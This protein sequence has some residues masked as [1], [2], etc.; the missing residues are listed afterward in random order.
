MNANESKPEFKQSNSVVWWSCWVAIALMLVLTAITLPQASD[1]VPIHWGFDGKPNQNAPALLALMLIPLT[2]I[3]AL[4]LALLL[5]KIDPGRANYRNFEASYWKVILAFLIYLGGFHGLVCYAAAGHEVN[6]TSALAVMVGILLIVIGNFMGKLRP[7]WMI[8]IRTPWTLSS[9]RSWDKTH[10]LGRW[11]TMLMGVATGL[12]ALAPRTAALMVVGAI[13]VAGL[14]TLVV[15]SWMVWRT[16]PN[17]VP[18]SGVL[19]EPEAKTQPNDTSARIMLLFIGALLVEGLLATPGRCQEPAPE[20]QLQTPTGVLH[21]S[22]DLPTETAEAGK[23]V[24]VVLVLPGSGP[25]DADGNSSMTKNDSLKQLGEALAKSGYAV[26]RIDKRGVGRSSA[27]IVKE[28]DLRFDTY[29]DDAVAWI[30]HLKSDPRFS[31]VHLIGHSEGSLIAMLTA[32]QI[33]VASFVSI[34]GA[35]EDA[36]TLLRRQLTAQLP[37][38]TMQKVEIILKDLESDQPVGEIPN[39]MDVLFRPSVQPY[40]RSWLAYDPPKEIAK[41]D[42]TNVLI[43]QGS[44]DIQV[45]VNNADLLTKGMASANKVII[46]D[47]NHVLKEVAAKTL[48]DQQAQYTDP[49]IPLHPQLIAPIVE[50]FSKQ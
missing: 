10:R 35:G 43:I 23:R 2:S 36:G 48:A 30:K 33:E 49:S 31:K 1:K 13:W 6:M 25:T 26:C 29:V 38:A 37:P 20:L 42:S 50:F 22:L 14:L 3:G 46:A 18:P 34:A 21:A 4:L 45:S 7:N 5:P 39:G 47:M 9:K 32:Q 27:A 12:I 41:L 19:P 11:V 16:D 44:T 17:K 40:L 28:S 24:P 8:G 15:Y